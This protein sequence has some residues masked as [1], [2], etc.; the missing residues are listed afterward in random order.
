[1]TQ[2]EIMAFI[3]RKVQEY[4]YRKTIRDAELSGSIINKWRKNK[5]GMR[6]DTLIRLLDAWGYE[7][8]IRKKRTC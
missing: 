6:I 4:G 5:C 8:I 3:G 7:I 1:M 2:E